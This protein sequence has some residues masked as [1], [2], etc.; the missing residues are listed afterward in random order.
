SACL[1]RQQLSL[2]RRRPQRRRP[3]QPQRLR[4]RRGDSP[5]PEQAARRIR[6][7]NDFVV[8]PDLTDSR[9]A[10]Q[11][12]GEPGLSRKVAEVKSK[13]L[14]QAK[15]SVANEPQL[16]KRCGGVVLRCEQRADLPSCAVSCRCQRRLR[17]AAV[18]PALLELQRLPS[19]PSARE[20]L[21]QP[22]RAAVNTEAKAV[23]ME[24]GMRRARVWL[25]SGKWPGAWRC[26]R[27]PRLQP[28]GLR[29]RNP[30]L[31]FFHHLRCLGGIAGDLL[32]GSADCAACRSWRHPTCRRQR[33]R[34]AS[35]QA[36]T[37]LAEPPR[38]RE[39]Q[40]A[41]PGGTLH[42]WSRSG[43]RLINH[44]RLQSRNRH[45]RIG[46]QLGGGDVAHWAS[47]SAWGAVPMR[48]STLTSS[49]AVLAASPTK[50]VARDL[51]ACCNSCRATEPEPA[52]TAGLAVAT[53]RH[54]GQTT[55]PGRAK[56]AAQLTAER[57]GYSG[58]SW[59]TQRSE[60]CGLRAE[61]PGRQ[62]LKGSSSCSRA[63]A[64]EDFRCPEH[65]SPI[66]SVSDEARNSDPRRS[67]RCQLPSVSTA[68]PEQ[69]LLP[70]IPVVGGS[71]FVSDRSTSRYS[72]GRKRATHSLMNNLARIL[73]R[74][75]ILVV[76]EIRDKRA[77]RRSLRES[78]AEVL[79]ERTVADSGDRFQREPYEVRL[80]LRPAGR[81]SSST[82]VLTVVCLHT[83][84]DAS[85]EELNA[86]HD[87]LRPRRRENLL[88][89]GDLNADCRYVNRGE[90]A[91]LPLRLDPD[92]L[93]LI[94]DG[95]DTT[96]ASVQQFSACFARWT[97]FSL[98]QLKPLRPSWIT[99]LPV[100]QQA[101]H[102]TGSNDGCLL[103]FNREL[104][105]LAGP[106]LLASSMLTETLSLEPSFLPILGKTG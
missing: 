97:A 96:F 6:M 85:V 46:K 30:Q 43:S 87:M 76:M 58:L 41:R 81:C 18:S 52:A 69:P 49:R 24:T 73:N 94:G 91:A 29:R 70:G 54:V 53:S 2:E 92:F 26:R 17:M 90:M 38:G 1:R 51:I 60:G 55:P 19:V 80:A 12:V 40:S 27:P 33:W 63:Q 88:I 98:L 28:L 8:A 106:P 102:C 42:C 45:R 32:G 15:C 78:V 56:P 3:Q 23:A 9:A 57:A 4:E 50:A 13:L 22:E 95:V 35:V 104:T 65:S 86:L 99:S 84:P 64:A 48:D 74:Y 89:A 37:W 71:R 31:Q 93:W 67:S 105:F 103:D 61:A 47:Q 44:R 39:E 101:R 59:A 25:A 68:F 20:R 82:T 16:M 11:S 77:I 79:S 66:V 83:E 5:A 21:R 7:K 14:C 100:L 34:S 62:G 36:S 72:A 10:G 75:D